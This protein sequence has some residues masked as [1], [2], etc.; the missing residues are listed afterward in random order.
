MMHTP[1]L[2]LRSSAGIDHKG[3][4]YKPIVYQDKNIFEVPM[5][6]AVR[7][8]VK[9][10]MWQ[11]VSGRG[12]GYAA[13]VD[14]FDVCGKTG[15][16]QMVSTDKATKKTQDHAWFMGFAPRDKPELG[17]VIL[18]ENAGQGGRQSAPRAKPILEYYYRRTRGI[19][20]E[21]KAETTKAEK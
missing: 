6:A 19:P 8:L 1:H 4:F 12:T 10:G 2:F 17:W 13:N 18:T 5:S 14:G 21:V 16:A 20:E 3:I 7:E 9:K 15:T 11:A